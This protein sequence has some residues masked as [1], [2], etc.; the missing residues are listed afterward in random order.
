MQKINFENLPSTNT[1]I[2]ATNLNQMQTNMEES[3][4]VISSTKP[5]TNEK[6]WIQKGKNLF[7]KNNITPDMSYVNDGTIT[8]LLDAFI[9][10][11]YIPVESSTNYIFS[12]A[13]SLVDVENGRT[14]IME[15]DSNYNFVKRNIAV[16]SGTMAITTASNTKY[17]RLCGSS[18]GLDTYQFE[19]GGTRTS[20]E[21]YVEK[22]I[23]VDGAE[24]LNVEKANNQQNYSTEEQ[25]VGTWIDGKPLYRKTFSEVPLN[26]EIE[27]TDCNVG[28]A[29][30]KSGFLDMVYNSQNYI[31]I[32]PYC[33]EGREIYIGIIDNKVIIYNTLQDW[34]NCWA[35]IT[36]EYTKTTD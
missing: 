16:Y 31:H 11:S 25:I 32:L 22:K 21:A 7:N 29:M 5:N 26:T 10:E 20:F 23:Y 24:F 30:L 35:T 14:V 27:I 3:G 33:R 19:Q 4:V 13:S 34:N 1:P 15:Y 12:T 18:I 36:L 9:Q 28:I 17:V 8:T 6:V 2:N